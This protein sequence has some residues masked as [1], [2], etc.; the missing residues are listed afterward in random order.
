ME[1]T[2]FYRYYLCFTTSETKDLRDEVCCPRSEAGWVKNQ[3]L[4]QTE[5]PNLCTIPWKPCIMNT[6]FS[7]YYSF[8]FTKCSLVRVCEVAIISQKQWASEA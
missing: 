5:R 4:N 2:H 3:N 1:D 6:T 8:P 7:S